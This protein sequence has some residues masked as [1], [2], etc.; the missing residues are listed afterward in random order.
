MR[1][2]GGQRGDPGGSCRSACEIRVEC[3]LPGACLILDPRAATRG[4]RASAGGLLSG[5]SLAG[6][7]MGP[8]RV[9]SGLQGGTAAL[10]P[11]PANLALALGR[12]WHRADSDSRAGLQGGLGK[13]PIKRCLALTGKG[14]RGI[15][16]R[17]RSTSG[18][19]Y[20]CAARPSTR[21]PK[22]GTAMPT[23]PPFWGC[24]PRG[25]CRYRRAASG[26]HLSV[27]GGGHL[28]FDRNLMRPS[29]SAQ[30][31]S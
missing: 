7:S 17:G 27:D 19:Q 1:G 26:Y 15:G 30:T 29:T 9:S 22:I 20:E 31:C 21:Y 2:S 18:F 6:D 13:G 10:C 24:P 12:G 8:G 28:C 11:H 25:G 3:G 5:P 4:N 14:L 23:A 16:G